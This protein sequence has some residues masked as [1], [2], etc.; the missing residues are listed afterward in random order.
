MF[1]L[2]LIMLPLA[3]AVLAYSDGSQF[4]FTAEPHS[5]WLVRWGGH[6]TPNNDVWFGGSTLPYP[7]SIISSWE[8]KWHVQWG[9]HILPYPPSVISSWELKWP[10]Q[11][12]G[13][14]L[15]YPPSVFSSW[16]L[17]WHAMRRTPYPT[18]PLVIN[19]WELQW[20]E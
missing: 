15:S 9:G 1:I 7:S 16:E 20:H 2:R 6:L 13:H 17:K 12:G 10:V 19:S 5:A 18:A 11:W 3:E 14:T 4:C 8:L